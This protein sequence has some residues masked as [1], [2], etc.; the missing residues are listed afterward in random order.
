MV[1]SQRARS[2]TQK[3]ERSAAILQ[4]ARELFE[5]ESF[6][7]ISMA[8]IAQK[9]GMAK[10][11]VFLYFKTKEELFF[12]IA[13]EEFQSWLDSMDSLFTNFSQ[14]R[15]RPNTDQF[16]NL[17]TEHL[18]P[19]TLLMRMIVIFHTV[20][21]HNISYEQ[22][23][24]FKQMMYDR[25]PVTGHLLEQCVPGLRSGQGFKFIM[26][27]YAL[28]IGFQHMSEPAPIVREVYRR[29]KPLSSMHLDFKEAYF[30]ALKTMLDGWIAQN[31][32]NH[33]SKP[34]RGGKG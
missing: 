12:I 24:R 1:L 13:V 33:A 28:V 29:N 16:L 6:D 7:R 23:L 5:H 20:L 8:G 22:A 17:L 32:R 11:T 26:W 21:E 18:A 4:V 34:S 9:A 31:Q 30:D 10:G 25:L 3:D 2:Q 14:N 19:F 27:M 15:K